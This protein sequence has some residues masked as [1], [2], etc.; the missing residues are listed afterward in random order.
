MLMPIIRHHPH[1]RT[2]ADS[3]RASSTERGVGSESTL[4]GCVFGGELENP[5]AFSCVFPMTRR[6]LE[7]QEKGGRFI[8]N[9]PRKR[10]SPIAVIWMVKSVVLGHLSNHVRGASRMARE[11]RGRESASLLDRQ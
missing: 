7:E 6:G 5:A 2:Q 4:L 3:C 10:I 11:W 1:S 9:V 8:P